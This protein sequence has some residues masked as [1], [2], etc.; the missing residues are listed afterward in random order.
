MRAERLT[1]VFSRPEYRAKNENMMREN[2]FFVLFMANQNT[3]YF[4]SF[5]IW[6]KSFGASI[7]GLLNGPCFS[8]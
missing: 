4:I 3:D 6:S 1:R 5:I 7:G 2:T 8:L